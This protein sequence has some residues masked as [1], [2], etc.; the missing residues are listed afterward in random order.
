MNLY[1]INTI[2]QDLSFFPL[3]YILQKSNYS[4]SLILPYYTADK[5]AGQESLSADRPI[6]SNWMEI[7]DY[8]TESKETLDKTFDLLLSYP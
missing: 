1:S 6:L 2:K 4:E 3:T 8:D 7:L 5:Q